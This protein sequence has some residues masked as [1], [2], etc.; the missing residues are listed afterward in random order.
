MLFP[1]QSPPWQPAVLWTAYG[2]PALQRSTITT[3]VLL[4]AVFVNWKGHYVLQL[5]TSLTLLSLV[6]DL[7]WCDFVAPRC[8]SK[9][10][11]LTKECFVW[12][13]SFPTSMV[14]KIRT[15]IKVMQKI[16]RSQFLRCVFICVT[17]RPCSL[18]QWEINTFG[19][20]LGVR[21]IHK[22]CR[23]LYLRASIKAM[24]PNRNP[25]SQN[26]K[27]EKMICSMNVSLVSGPCPL[28]AMTGSTTR[29]L[30]ASC[31]M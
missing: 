3:F 26:T 2:E 24:R 11:T 8:Q 7:H 18:Q 23:Q 4:A 6:S 15:V 9:Q 17:N 1:D 10:G 20:F 12:L 5:L 13:S 28:L 19:C 31:T 25:H 30:L 21:S 27:H 14:S 16:V 22:I 29:P